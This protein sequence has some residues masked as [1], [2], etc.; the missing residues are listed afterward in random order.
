MKSVVSILIPAFNEER[1]IRDTIA[2]A[3]DQTWPHTEIIVVDDGSTDKTAAIA[4]RFA[5]ANV[6]IATQPHQGAPAARNHAFS[7][8]QG[9]YIQWLD[10]D[11]LLAPDKIERQLSALDRTS[12]PRTVLSSAWG[13]FMHSRSRA[14]FVPTALWH[15]LSP[16]EWLLRRLEDNLYMQT[17]TWLVSR[18]VTAAAGQWDTR[19][20]VDDD[21]EYFCRVLLRSDVVRFVPEARVFYRMPDSTHLSYIGL[22]RV[23]MDSQFLSMQLH[24]AYLRSLEDSE[25]AR[26]ACVAYL[27]AGL[28]HFY[29]ERPDIIEQMQHLAAELGGRL[30]VR[31][32]PRKYALIGAAF[33]PSVAQRAQIFLPRIRWAAVRL[34]D[35]VLSAFG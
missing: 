15:D 23:K 31:R 9:D 16:V 34:W 21:G 12:G 22:S 25:R 28:I 17:A 14:R 2:S 11:D 32:L 3:I 5:S 29:P 6:K 26:G 33:G 19:L 4:R 1:W 18:E 24:V 27:Q 13:R 10:A 20:L 30:D 8:C 35:K 7:L